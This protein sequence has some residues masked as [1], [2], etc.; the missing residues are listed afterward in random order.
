MNVPATPR[1]VLPT[2]ARPAALAMALAA[3]LVL[4]LAGCS[5]PPEKRNVQPPV[6]EGNV[7]RFA[8]D[9]P[10]KAVLVSAAVEENV[11]DVVR[12]PGRLA[13]DETRTVRVFAP[14][15]GR[16]TRIAAEPGQAVQQGAVLVAQR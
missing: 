15:A 3:A 11:S 4:T 14:L 10:Q 5:K 16:I 6:V 13:W 9:S 7:I 2:R 1:P 12:I 8:A